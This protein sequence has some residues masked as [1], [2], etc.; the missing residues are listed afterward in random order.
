MTPGVCVSQLL[1]LSRSRGCG[2]RK[3]G[4]GEVS[5][6]VNGV[7]CTWICFISPPRCVCASSCASAPLA[8]T[9]AESL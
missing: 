2:G 1:K 5:A 9:L 4:D 8:D 3:G 7:N 6:A